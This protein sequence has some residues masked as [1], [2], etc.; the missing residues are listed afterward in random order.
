VERIKRVRKRLG[1]SLT[2]V[3][4]RCGLLPEAVARAERAGQ[5]PRGSTLAAIAK[6]LGVPVC[7]LFD[8]PGA[9][10]KRVHGRAQSGRKGVR[11]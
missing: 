2:D 9:R 7:E 5:D 3:A 4:S 8:D 10:G 11:R 6:A 1:M